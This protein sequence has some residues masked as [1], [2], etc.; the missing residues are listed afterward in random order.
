[1]K[2]EQFTTVVMLFSLL[3]P[4][5]G[6]VLA[7]G[8]KVWT[9]YL[10]DTKCSEAVKDDSDPSDFLK[11]HT[12]DCALMPNCKSAGYILYSKHE[13]L[14]FDDAGNKKAV[15]LLKASKKKR[16]FFVEVRASREGN[17]LRT[18]S[19]K[20]IAEPEKNE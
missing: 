17:L 19:I 5:G 1:M 14:K 13:W 15:E 3:Q 18:E 4:N 8:E 9:G 20:E 7:E 6:E 2:K 11:H 10:S 12:K 16:G